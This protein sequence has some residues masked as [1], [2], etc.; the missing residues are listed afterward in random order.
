S[1]VRSSQRLPFDSL[2]Y[3]RSESRQVVHLRKIEIDPKPPLDLRDEASGWDRV[4]K[5]TNTSIVVIII[6]WLVVLEEPIRDRL[7]PL[8]LDGKEPR[9][10]KRKAAKVRLVV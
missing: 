4:E 10:P 3:P 9:P 6:E 8:E 7:F 5:V 2:P 1:L